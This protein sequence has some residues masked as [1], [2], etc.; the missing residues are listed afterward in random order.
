MRIFASYSDIDNH[1]NKM[2]QHSRTN[3]DTQ[4]ILR[5]DLHQL[6][7]QYYQKINLLERHSLKEGDYWL[8][9]AKEH[10][11]DNHILFK[12]RE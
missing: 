6:L 9:K 2:L 3:E 4:K 12:Y 1:K 8:V 5:T 11:L 7:A 10:T